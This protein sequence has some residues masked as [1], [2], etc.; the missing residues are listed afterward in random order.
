MKKNI[1]IL[2]FLLSIPCFSQVSHDTVTNWQIY[3][4]NLLLYKSH[5]SDFNNHTMNIQS[6]DNFKALKLYINS[7]VKI[8][9]TRR[10]LL[11][12]QNDKLIYSFIRL[13]KSNN[14]PVVITNAELKRIIGP[15]LNEEFL[16]EYTDGTESSGQK[17]GSIIL[18][19]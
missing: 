9:E 3:K 6:S 12:K 15:S 2:F 1:T 7:D 14:D 18:T 8:A 5:T 4:D 13:L 11:F 17:I 10:K 16:I 19:D